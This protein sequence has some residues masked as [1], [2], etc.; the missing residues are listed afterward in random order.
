[1]H[2]IELINKWITDSGSTESYSD[3]LRAIQADKKMSS[4]KDLYMLSD[5]ESVAIQ[6]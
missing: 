2:E 1:M 3:F 6:F 5:L 4:F